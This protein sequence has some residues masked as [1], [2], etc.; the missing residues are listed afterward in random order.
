[1]NFTP[2]GTP[3]TGSL[4]AGH[5]FTTTKLAHQ[6]GSAGNQ[7]LGLISL[8]ES[9]VTYLRPVDMNGALTLNVPTHSG[10]NSTQNQQIITLP[11]SIPGSKPGEISS[12]QTL[13]ILVNPGNDKY[14][15][16]PL[17]LQHFQ[18]GALTVAYSNAQ[19]GGES[20]QLQVQTQDE[21]GTV[22]PTTQTQQDDQNDQHNN[23][24][25]NEDDGPPHTV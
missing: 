20:I 21:N 3:F 10:N 11:I 25:N 1:M 4:P 14:Q 24:N 13:Q 7:V 18:Q 15:C 5:Q 23:N 8:D 9:G 17:S 6:I 16:V 12:Q 22:D 19:Q 2:Y